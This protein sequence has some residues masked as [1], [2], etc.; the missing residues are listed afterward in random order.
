MEAANLPIQ[1]LEHERNDQQQRP[2]PVAALGRAPSRDVEYNEIPATYYLMQQQMQQMP[3]PMRDPH[4][5]VQQQM[6]QMSPQMQGPHNYVLPPAGPILTQGI[7]W[8]HQLVFHWA[9][10]TFS[11]RY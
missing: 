9:W 10:V 2:P 7:R 3:P 4:N 11:K 1:E 5:S 8:K 6:Q